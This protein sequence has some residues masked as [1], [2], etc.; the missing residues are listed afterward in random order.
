M[1]VSTMGHS[2][3]PDRGIRCAFWRR[4]ASANS[5][6]FEPF[7]GRGTIHNSTAK[8]YRR[9]WKLPDQYRHLPGLGG[10]RHPRK[11]SINI[12]WRNASF[13]GYADYMQTPEFTE[14]LNQ[15]IE[16]ASESPHRDHVRRGSSVAL[17]SL[18]DC[19]RFGGARCPGT[20]NT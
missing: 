11:D 5:W 19:G 4:T 15:F 3:H 1:I 20:R 9:A 16:L 13:R 2:T 17:P 10:L 14:N 6:M 8:T 12:G 7:Q 18:A